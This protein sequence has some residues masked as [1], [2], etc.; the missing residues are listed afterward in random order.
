MTQVT[1]DAADGTLEDVIYL[2]GVPSK[3]FGSYQIPWSYTPHEDGSYHVEDARGTHIFRVYVEN[4]Q[5]LNLLN[6]KIASVNAG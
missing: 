5:D 6:Q 2:K 4:N 1:E 3:N